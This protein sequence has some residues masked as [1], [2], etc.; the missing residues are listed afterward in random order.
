[1]EQAD[2]GD[3]R[4][5]AA[6]HSPHLLN[7]D[8]QPPPPG[9]ESASASSS[10]SGSAFGLVLSVVNLGRIPLP[11]SPEL[12]TSV[13]ADGWDVQH[14]ELEHPEARALHGRDSAVIA[15]AHTGKRYA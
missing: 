6:P 10:A 5:P 7:P 14:G 9:Y 8:P 1:M 2:T 12:K 3:P 15:A 11:L 13:E 4:S